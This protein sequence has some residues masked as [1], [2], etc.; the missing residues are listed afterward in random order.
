M[1]QIR[2][3]YIEDNSKQRKNFAGQLRQKGFTVTA[4]VSGKTALKY[5]KQ[6]TYD[7]VLCDLN[8]PDLNGLDILEEIRREGSKILFVILTAHGTISQAVKAI[9]KAPIILSL[10]P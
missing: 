7:A 5:L 2:I 1:K 8:L 10:N 9:K 4:A 6:R 3:L